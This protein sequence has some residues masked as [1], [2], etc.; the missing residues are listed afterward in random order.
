MIPKGSIAARL[1]WL[2]ALWLV[3]ALL[4][5]AFLLSELY[6]RALDRGLVDSLEFNI[7]TLVAR[8]LEAGSADAETVV[9]AD[10]RFQRPASGWY[11]QI[12]GEDGSLYNLSGSVVGSMM[13][14]AEAPFDE[15]GSRTTVVEDDFGTRVRLI[16]RRVNT[17]GEDLRFAV[18]GNLDEISEET[19]NFRS[20][21]LIVLFAVGVM[22]AVMSAIVARVALRPVGQLRQEIEQVREGDSSRV[23]GDYPSELVPLATELNE[24]LRSNAE[25]VER[26]RSHVGN[27]AH[28]LKT[29]LA[30]LR[31]EAANGRT[32]L[33][34]TVSAETDRMS[35]LVTNYLDRARLAARTAVVGQRA[36][37]G[38]VL[39]RLVRVMT[40]IHA[41]TS[42]KFNAPTGGQIWFRGE[43]G[44]LEEMAGNLLDNACKWAKSEVRVAMGRVAAEPGSQLLVTIEDDGPGMT[45]EE[46]EKA[47]KRGVRLDEKVPGSGLGL[48]IVKELVDIYGGSLE[49]SD[50][51]LGGVAVKLTLPAAKNP[52]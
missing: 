49:L 23:T 40:K 20:Q 35:T 50:S 47:L 5:T 48:D 11:W 15:L 12:T 7:E 30:V 22:L 32:A 14:M 10:P 25:I 38:E 39:T 42:V 26:A 31:N 36:D 27:L 16:E 9:A 44:D 37:A 33:A 4:A 28:G 19:A 21:T 17:A 29:P 43:E 41:D 1:F 46:R 51:A 18:T 52:N 3:F 45:G 34:K 2:S 8:T 6:S 13:P 24:L